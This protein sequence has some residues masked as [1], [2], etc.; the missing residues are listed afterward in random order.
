[1]D[2]AE[3]LIVIGVVFLSIRFAI[4]SERM[5]QAL[6]TYGAYKER[7]GMFTQMIQFRRGY[8]DA[9]EDFVREQEDN[10]QSAK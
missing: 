4:R 5:Y 7:V 1:M 8:N 3:V 9:R 10:R 6:K 2:N